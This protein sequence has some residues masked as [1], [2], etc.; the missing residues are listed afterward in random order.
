MILTREANA[1][2]AGVARR[3]DLWSG[4]KAS[5]GRRTARGTLKNF[6]PPSADLNHAILQSKRKIRRDQCTLRFNFAHARY[7]RKRGGTLA[8]GL[9][10]EPGTVAPAHVSLISFCASPAACTP[11][12]QNRG[13]HNIES[14]P[15][16]AI[17]A[18]FVHHCSSKFGLWNFD[19]C[20]HPAVES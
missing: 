4:Y 9:R 19:F 16:L 15:C 3:G 12:T 13:A 2:S 10:L 18:D 5:A 11:P 8:R 6:K 7:G 17:V 1:R 14:F 20:V